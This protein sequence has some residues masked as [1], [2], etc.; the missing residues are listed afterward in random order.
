MKPG[1]VYQVDEAF[2][3]ANQKAIDFPQAEYERDKAEFDRIAFQHGYRFA[4]IRLQMAV[5]TSKPL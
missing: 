1:H 4:G 3:R 5:F 2:A